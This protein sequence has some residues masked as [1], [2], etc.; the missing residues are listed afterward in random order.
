VGDFYCLN[1]EIDFINFPIK[2]RGLPSDQQAVNKFIKELMQKID[3]GE[4]V[5]IHCRMGIG[6]SSIIAGAILIKEGR[7]VTEIIDQISKVRE[8][9]V[10]DTDDQVRWL[11][12]FE[13]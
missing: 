10:P 1:H 3:Q 5:V 11:K 7:T 6:R 9:Q 13:R 2:D 4:K 12:Q 8:L